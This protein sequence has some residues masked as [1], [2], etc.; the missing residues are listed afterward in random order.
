MTAALGTILSTESVLKAQISTSSSMTVTSNTTPAQV[1]GVSSNLIAG[2]TYFFR[3]Y[4][5]ASAATTP[6]Y[7]FGID[8]S[9]TASMLNATL[10]VNFSSIY[11]SDYFT[12]LGSSTGSNT[13]AIP[14]RA[15]QIEGSITCSADG[16]FYPTF[17]QNTS[18]GTS[19]SLVA[20]ATLVV[21]EIS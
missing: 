9:A 15:V 4:G 3:F 21:T 19:I 2:K 17:A 14:T 5:V 7:K 20:G 11:I 8:G 18:S 12:T 1:T 6:G 16:T 13:G 10:L